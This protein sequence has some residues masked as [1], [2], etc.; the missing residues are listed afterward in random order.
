MKG[1]GFIIGN[2]IRDFFALNKIEILPW[3]DL[4]FIIREEKNLNLEEQALLDRLAQ[5]TLES[6]KSFLE[7]R[8]IYESNEKL[9]PPSDWLNG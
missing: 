6:D 7:L 4:S 5:V 9:H 8:S 3:D 2:L 1:A